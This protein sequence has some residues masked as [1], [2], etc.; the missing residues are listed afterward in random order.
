MSFSYFC[1]IFN[2]IS[3]GPNITDAN[4]Q[5]DSIKWTTRTKYLCHRKYE[6]AVQCRAHMNDKIKYTVEWRRENKDK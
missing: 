2:E 3:N 4:K 6:I 1:S 5:C